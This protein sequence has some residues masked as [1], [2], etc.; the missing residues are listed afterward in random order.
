MASWKVALPSPARIPSSFNMSDMFFRMRFARSWRLVIIV[1]SGAIAASD[2]TRTSPG[3]Y[4]A[5]QADAGRAVYLSHCASC[6][7]P[8]LAGSN[9]APALAGSNFIRAW[10]DRTPSY[11][12]SLPDK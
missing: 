10:G 9:E 11:V 1:T 6:H 7:L 2:Q 12:F 3:L 5:A 4:T 8:D